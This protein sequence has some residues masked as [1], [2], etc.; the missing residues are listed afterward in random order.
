MDVYAHLAHGQ[1]M[2]KNLDGWL[3]KAAEHAAA[4]HFDPNILAHARLAPDAFPLA[5]QVG[6][7]CDAMKYLAAYA[8]GRTAPSHPDTETTFTEVRQRI[9]TVLEHLDGFRREDFVGASDR[10]A[11]P[12]WLRGG[13]LALDDYLLH[14]AIPNFHFHVTMAYAILRHNGVPLGKAEFLGALPL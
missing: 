5:R 8:T 9:A 1:K 3:A 7:A 4:K 2:L 6:S 11:A 14:V 10:R 12:A 13:S